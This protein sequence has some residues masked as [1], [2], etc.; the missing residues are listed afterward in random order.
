M[1]R[2]PG[3]GT[4]EIQETGAE[5]QETGAEIQETD[6]EI[7]P[8]G[9]ADLTSLREFFAGLS[10]QTR[11]LRFFAPVAPGPAM[12]RR[13]AGDAGQVD[14]VIAICGEVI[15]GHAMAVDQDGQAGNRLSDIGVVVADAWQR[16]GV[17]AALMRALITRA[18]ARGVTS[19]A[20]DVLHGNRRVLAMIMSHWPAARTDHCTDCVT[21]HVRLDSANPRSAG[22][23]VGGWRRG[24]RPGRL[25]TG[26]DRRANRGPLAGT[27]S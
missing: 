18:Q 17:G 27:M 13:L 21:V 4:A 14:A 8:V 22:V 11:F 6:V 15:I 5:I 19:I 2:A 23:T 10:L 26:R 16:Q 25:I 12:L 3:G 9:A 7:R 24:K 1:E 20:M